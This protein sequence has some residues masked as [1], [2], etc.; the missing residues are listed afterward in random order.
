VLSSFRILIVEDEPFI[1]L[2]LQALVE[3]ARGVVIG[4][5]G[6]ASEALG[7]LETCAVSAAILDIQL[8]DRDVTPVAEALLAL[9]VPMIFQSAVGLPPG[10]Q[11]RCPDALV[12]RKPVSSEELISALAEIVRR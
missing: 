7:L 2:E 3:E 9:N 4:P 12:Y 5:V 10:L 8:S 1:A 6:S 11:L